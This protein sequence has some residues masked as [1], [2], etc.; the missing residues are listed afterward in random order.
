MGLVDH[1]GPVGQRHHVILNRPCCREARLFD[2]RP[3]SAL[4]QTQGRRSTFR[5]AVSGVGKRADLVLQDLLHGL[6]AGLGAEAKTYVGAAD[7]SDQN[8]TGH[9]LAHHDF[10]GFRR[11]RHR[12]ARLAKDAR[13]GLRVPHG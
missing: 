2:S 6:S 4:G 3:V 9:G 11:L 10:F 5:T 12:Q 7:I 8:G 1:P 13:P